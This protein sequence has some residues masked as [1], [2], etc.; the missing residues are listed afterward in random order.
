MYMRSPFVDVSGRSARGFCE[1]IGDGDLE[2]VLNTA[3]E[4]L[5]RSAF[6]VDGGEH[7]GRIGVV[8]EM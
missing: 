6:D 5:S 2:F 1:R 4:F 8:D 7:L 3:G